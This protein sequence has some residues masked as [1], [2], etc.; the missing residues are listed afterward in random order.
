M[1]I[2]ATIFCRFLQLVGLLIAV[3]GLGR[4]GPLY[5]T[6]QAIIAK[7][8]P[9][10]HGDL[11]AKILPVTTPV[12]VGLLI[13]YV[14]QLAMRFWIDFAARQAAHPNQPWMWRKDWADQHIKFSSRGAVIGMTIAWLCYLLVG[15]PLA[16]MLASQK[17]PGMVYS[18]AGAI[19][20]F[21][22]L[23][24]RVLW[25]GRKWSNAELRLAANP[26]VV[27]GPIS[28]V[29]ILKE[30]FPAGTVFRIA[31]RCEQTE[32]R[33]ESD[34]GP[35][36][37]VEWQ[38]QKLLDRTIESEP[39]Q[40][41]LPFHFAIPFDST[42]TSEHTITRNKGFV[43]QRLARISYQWYVEA[44]L[45]D[46]SLDKARFEVPVF[47][48][49]DSS[50]HYKADESLVD[51]YRHKPEAL[52]VLQK[53]GCAEEPIG[54]GKRWRFHIYRRDI[55]VTLVVMEIL[56]AAGLTAN[57]LW[58]RPWPVPFFIALIPAVMGA[59]MLYG[60]FEMLFWQSTLTITADTIEIEAGY[61]GFRRKYA[62]PRDEP[63]YTRVHKE[64]ETQNG[65]PM[66]CVQFETPDGKHVNLVKKVDGNEDATAIREWLKSQW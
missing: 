52:A 7:R 28:G 55:F 21:L 46:N 56:I 39:S 43:D 40:T 50:P 41:A 32:S 63:P 64:F 14:V 27:G 23:F 66:F 31:L 60:M 38:D 1:G 17:N 34:S 8:Q 30:P 44:S 18:F 59:L 49:P 37:K 36:T 51:E 9:L 62:Y 48:T 16:V 61:A 35:S 19:G 57:F 22:L 3:V 5:E 29:I 12:L 20:L 6:V 33:A 24:S 13:V 10:N 2:V 58:V 4:A 65:P 42:P 15:V 53:I 47:E 54:K 45:R 11:A 25:L 26:G